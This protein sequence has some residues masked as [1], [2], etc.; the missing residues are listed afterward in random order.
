MH[1][2]LARG[3]LRTGLLG[4]CATVSLPIR[5]RVH[6]NGSV[7]LRGAIDPI[8]RE[9]RPLAMLAVLALM[10]PS[11]FALAGLHPPLA[12]T[13]LADGTVIICTDEGFA[14][15]AADDPATERHDL[16]CCIVCAHPQAPAVLVGAGPAADLGPGDGRRGDPIPPDQFAGSGIRHGPG[17]IRA[18]PAQPV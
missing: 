4:R 7:L 14:R 11:L 9:R 2:R 8:F 16:P 18:P 13:R 6:Y 3:P 15:V 10:L 12:T 1:S 17:A 5:P